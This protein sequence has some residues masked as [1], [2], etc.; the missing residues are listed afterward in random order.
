MGTDYVATSKYAFSRKVHGGWET[1]RDICVEGRKTGLK[2]M[3]E[4]RSNVS[5]NGKTDAISI[6]SKISLSIA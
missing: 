2:M 4:P 1:F 5:L 6:A 3:L